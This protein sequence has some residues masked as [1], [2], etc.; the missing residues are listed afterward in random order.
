MDENSI[1]TVK[2]VEKSNKSNFNSIVI[3][4][5]K[6][7]LSKNEI[8][9][10]KINQENEIFC[11]NLEN[12]ML[13]ERNYKNEIKTLFNK[14]NTLTKQEEQYLT[15][16]Q[17]QIC[18]ENFIESF[19]KDIEDN[20]TYKQKI[21]YYLI[22]LFNAY[23]LLLN[24]RLYITDEE[25]DIIIS[26]VK[27]YLQIFEEKEINYSS[28]LIKI[29]LDNED[30]IFGEFCIQVLSFYSQ[31]GTEYYHSF[32]KKNS[33]HYL[34]E[35]LSISEKYSVQEKIKNNS[36]LLYKFLSII[37]NCNELLNIIKA[38]S[39]EKY[40]KSF[41]NN[42]LIKEDEFKTEEEKIDIL[43]RFKDALSYLKN[44]KK[45]ADKLLK[46]FYLA[47][48]VKIEYKMFNSKNYILLL[49]IINDCIKLKIDVPQGCLGN[50]LDWFNEI[51]TIKTEIE[52]EQ[53]IAEENP[54]EVEMNIKEGINDIINEI[55][56]KFNKGKISF[57]FF[58][59]TEHKPIGLENDFIFN[60]KKDLE[61][62]YNSNKKKFMKKLLDFYL[63]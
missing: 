44:P 20:F 18:I 5:D 7:G 57:F 11:Q 32:D 9:S 23:S 12:T 41:S 19:H 51:C 62:V 61:E 60:N 3:K 15:L 24:F 29:F 2:A 8:E 31:K 26:N 30:V 50:N 10:A 35:A 16:K 40:C 13:M 47:N 36:E 21:Y 49:R 1:L 27:N 28:S 34:E 38:E 33:K 25:K 59:L 46:A 55:N 58:I 37:D 53:K 63:D 45:R 17:F 56:E 52:R 54:E 39:I 48:I 43:D 22:Y 4:N 42:I 14:I 6:G